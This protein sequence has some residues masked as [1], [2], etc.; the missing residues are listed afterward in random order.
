MLPRPWPKPYSSIPALETLEVI[1]AKPVKNNFFELANLKSI[2]L[3]LAIED[4]IGGLSVK[5]IE[6]L[7]ELHVLETKYL[8][9]TERLRLIL[10]KLGKNLK[11]FG[12]HD[13]SPDSGDKDARN[14]EIVRNI[15]AQLPQLKEL[16]L[17]AGRH[18]HCDLVNRS[19]SILYEELKNLRT[20]RTYLKLDLSKKTG[21]DDLKNFLDAL[22]KL[23]SATFDNFIIEDA[24]DPITVLDRLAAIL[25][26]YGDKHPKRVIKF[27]F[28]IPFHVY[29]F[30]KKLAPNVRYSQ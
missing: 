25:S 23:R 17:I 8:G 6:R 11:T 2:K 29:Q 12:Y 14:V 20:F 18:G 28:K 15:A 13:A 26:S 19:S 1:K 10:S 16:T 3:P 24:T 22:P 4:L 21:L 5:H 7:V 30:K 27:K 9:R